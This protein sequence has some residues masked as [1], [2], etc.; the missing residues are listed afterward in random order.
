MDL[1]PLPSLKWHIILLKIYNGMDH[2][3][4]NQQNLVLYKIY[5]EL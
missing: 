2:D 4:L 1:Q 3:E 5:H